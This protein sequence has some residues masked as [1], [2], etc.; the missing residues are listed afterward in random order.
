MSRLLP[1]AVSN[2]FDDDY[3]DNEIEYDSF[4]LSAP[5]Q[6]DVA[7][8]ET[9]LALEPALHD[10]DDDDNN[11]NNDNDDGDAAAFFQP[12]PVR[13]S[14]FVSS[15]DLL[16]QS[17]DSH[18]TPVPEPV[19]V[20][21]ESDALYDAAHSKPLP[22]LPRK[23]WVA[24]PASAYQA[25]PPTET[26][27]SAKSVAEFANVSKAAA[28]RALV[29]LA[30]QKQF[31]RLCSI[32]NSSAGI[33]GPLNDRVDA[34]VRSVQAAEWSRFADV[35]VIFSLLSWLAVETEQ[36]KSV[37]DAV[38]ARLHKA[39]DADASLRTLVQQA[40]MMLEASQVENIFKHL[41][42]SQIA[43]F[44]SGVSGTAAK[45]LPRTCATTW[46]TLSHSACDVLLVNFDLPKA[47]SIVQFPPG[48][49][50][51]HRDALLVAADT[52]LHAADAHQSEIVWLG[53]AVR[54]D[55]SCMFADLPLTNLAALSGSDTLDDARLSG[56]ATVSD[57]QG[58]TVRCLKS[59]A[60]V[61]AT[62]DK[63]L[64]LVIDFQK[65]AQWDPFFQSGTD[66]EQFGEH[67]FVRRAVYRAKKC[68]LVRA[69]SF[70]YV[71]QATP[72]EDGGWLVAA[73]SV[74]DPRAGGDNGT[75]RGVIEASGWLLLP[76]GNQNCLAVH[77][78]LIAFGGSVP[79]N[80]YA[81]IQSRL[82]LTISHMRKMCH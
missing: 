63:V 35:R 20:V 80:V 17:D 45:T 15:A 29:A 31:E 2:L 47:K 11:N 27:V 46:A 66:I 60:V 58:G 33:A 18:V 10:D 34:G 8:V 42:V 5:R 69:R 19:P 56:V 25:V 71:L 74:D 82:P 62:P 65:V 53:K 72:L 39:C 70:V 78:Q 21:A 54:D 75:V 41:H 6:L 1:L 50:Q 59:V 51:A 24:P 9:D 64:K 81:L 57:T 37:V 76:D 13:R 61:P 48:L 32:L 23:K 38:M 26:L 44:L 4:V 30:S 68:S 52:I 67:C 49:S 22:A 16:L 73:R 77:I 55:V 7:E 79:K 28:A 3:D 12:L 40:S 43:W 14:E 36:S